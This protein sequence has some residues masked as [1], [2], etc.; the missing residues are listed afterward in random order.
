[1][2]IIF[3]LTLLFSITD[4]SAQSI[5][6]V[7]TWSVN[8]AS[9]TLSEAGTDYGGTVTSSPSQSFISLSGLAWLG[10]YSVSVRKTDVI[11]DSSLSLK[12]RRTGTGTFTG[13][14]SSITGG[15]TFITLTNVNQ[16]F[17]TGSNFIN[18]VRNNIPIQYEIGGIS[19]L[20]PVRSYS[21]TVVYTVSN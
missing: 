11:W 2:R 1:M 15:E 10:S 12:V 18:T 21:T 5:S 19:V 9:N 16:T 14:S 7:G 13:W 3:I 20:L 6:I 4:S 8:I 17:F